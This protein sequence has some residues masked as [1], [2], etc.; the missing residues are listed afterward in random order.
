MDRK[1]KSPLTGGETSLIKEFETSD[2][3][4]RYKD[5]FN[6]DV[7]NFF[8]EIDNFYLFKCNE[9]GYEFYAPFTLSGNE[10]FYKELS[11][12]EWYYMPWKWEHEQTL[13]YASKANTILE[14]GCGSGSYLKKIQQIFPNKRVTGLEI[15]IVENAEPFIINQTVEDHA[16][17]NFQQYDMICSFQ[18]LE[19]ITYVRSFLEASL[20][21]L[22]PGGCLVISVPNNDSIFFQEKGEVVL[23]MPPHHMGLWNRKSLSYLTKVFPILLRKTYFEPIQS[24][25][26][27]WF[28]TIIQEK[29]KDGRLGYFK[30]L[31][32]NK[33]SLRVIWYVLARFYRGHSIMTIYEKK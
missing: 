7:R 10:D 22:K 17:Q 15:T 18:V 12:F 20:K 9:S 29:M 31:F 13:N 30:K 5:Q 1:I 6:I 25:H 11:S 14:V 4:K 28:K 32:V 3:V 33:Y 26:F 23:N 8:D 21:L 2:I 24:Y 16:A 27:L 19:H